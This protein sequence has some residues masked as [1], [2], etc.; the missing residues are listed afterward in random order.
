MI[1]SGETGYVAKISGNSR[2]R[3]H[4]AELGF[5]FGSP[6]TVVAILNG[7]MIVGI[8]ATRIAISSEVANRIFVSDK[9]IEDANIKTDQAR[10]YRHG[11]QAARGRICEAPSDGYGYHQ[12]D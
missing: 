7:S 5:T 8:K 3:H 1:G 9:E 4:I 11:R 12:G 10:R 2:M 6:V